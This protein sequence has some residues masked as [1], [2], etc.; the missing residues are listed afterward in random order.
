[1][2]LSGDFYS[3][4]FLNAPWLRVMARAS[5]A[6]LARILGAA[7]LALGLMDVHERLHEGE[8]TSD[9]PISSGQE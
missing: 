8:I 7:L 9:L 3:D 5:T 1:M 4:S 2:G 6:F